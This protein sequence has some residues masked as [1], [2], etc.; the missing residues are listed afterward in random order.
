[1]ENLNLDWTR[2]KLDAM[3]HARGA[4]KGVVAVIVSGRLGGEYGT[5]AVGSSA[6]DLLCTLPPSVGIYATLPSCDPGSIASR[7]FALWKDDALKAEPYTVVSD[8][9]EFHKASPDH[10][11]C[12]ARTFAWELFAE[13]NP[14][15]IVES[16][17]TASATA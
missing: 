5:V 11:L 17:G 15:E 2:A 14:V 4:V 12:D 16:W 1:M 6:E 8:G 13:Q 9:V 7:I 3:A 10:L